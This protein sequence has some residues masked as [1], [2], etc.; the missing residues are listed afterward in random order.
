MEYISSTL[1]DKHQINAFNFE[2]TALKVKLINFKQ[3][4]YSNKMNI[5]SSKI[6][7]WNDCTFF[8]WN[9]GMNIIL[10]KFDYPFCFKIYLIINYL[11]FLLYGK[12]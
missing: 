7:L 4:Y 2:F 1:R 3:T 9:M 8:K 11:Y 6:H 12:I 10:I 5:L